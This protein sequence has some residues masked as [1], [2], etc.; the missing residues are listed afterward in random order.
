MHKSFK[1]LMRRLQVH[2]LVTEQRNGVS[3]LFDP[4]W[5]NTTEPQFHIHNYDFVTTVVVLLLGKWRH[6]AP[7]G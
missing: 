2:D 6:L 7:Q 1:A 5:E 4:S 3:L